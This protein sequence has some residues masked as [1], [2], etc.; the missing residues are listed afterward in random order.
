MDD[1][2]IQLKEAVNEIRESSVKLDEEIVLD[3]S[4]YTKKDS[5]DPIVKPE[6]SVDFSKIQNKMMPRVKHLIMTIC[7]L[8]HHH[9]TF[10]KKISF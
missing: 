2:I 7:R 5:Q 9:P 1:E 6:L 4:A 8:L 3:K 10:H